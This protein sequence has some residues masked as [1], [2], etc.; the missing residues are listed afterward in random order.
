MDWRANL[1]TKITRLGTISH[2]W[3]RFENANFVRKCFMER[4]LG[5]IAAK[6]LKMR[7]KGS[8]CGAEIA[9]LTNSVEILMYRFHVPK[10]LTF[11]HPFSLLHSQFS[12]SI[13]PL[14]PPSSLPHSPHPSS[15][16]YLR[17]LRGSAASTSLA[18]MLDRLACKRGS[19]REKCR[20]MRISARP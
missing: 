15:T 2:D 13:L 14:H 6:R 1:F 11:H 16:L 18:F 19:S 10:C 12:R 17:F 7:K 4:H 3:A 20:K 9:M 8:G 5:R